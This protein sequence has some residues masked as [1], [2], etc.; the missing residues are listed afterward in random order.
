VR[1]ALERADVATGRQPLER[2]KKHTNAL[3]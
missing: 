2:R 3:S 1:V